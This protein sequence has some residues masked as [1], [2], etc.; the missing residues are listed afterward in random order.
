MTPEQIQRLRT[1]L[2]LTQTEFAQRLNVTL[3][4]VQRWESGESSKPHPVFIAAMKEL[5]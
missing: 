1:R 5:K 2:G 4:T 3:R